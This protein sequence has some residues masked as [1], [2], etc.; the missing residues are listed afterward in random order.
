MEEGKKLGLIIM[1]CV[2]EQLLL[3]R[4]VEELV[5]PKLEEVVAA[6]ETKIDDAV[7]A[8]V[9]EVLQKVAVK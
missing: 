2:D 3:K 8:M 6:S 4:V 7:L 5:M 1:E 9:K